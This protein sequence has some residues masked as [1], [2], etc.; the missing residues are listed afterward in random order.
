MGDDMAAM[1]N[2]VRILDDVDRTIVRALQRD[3]RTSNH[4]LAQEAGIAASTCV[5]RLRSL[6]ERGVLRGIHADVDPAAL[7]L[8]LQ[9]M[10]AVSLRPDRRAAVGDFATE[11]AA[12][13]YVVNAFYVSGS[14]DH[15][16]HV[17]AADSEALR[18]IVNDLSSMTAVAGTETHL[19]FDHVAGRIRT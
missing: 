15:L 1:S 7:G 12:R 17:A 16:V 19:I 4:T 6:R 11:V 18:E 13:P 9:A 8:S 2:D 14:Y 3:G 5:V 10:I